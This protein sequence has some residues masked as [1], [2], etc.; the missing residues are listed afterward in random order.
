[1][2][3]GEYFIKV[4]LYGGYGTYKLSIDFEEISEEVDKEPNDDSDNAQ[5]ITFKSR[6][7]MGILGGNAD[8]RDTEDWYKLKITRAGTLTVKAKVLNEGFNVQLAIMDTNG[9]SQLVYG[10]TSGK[11]NGEVQ[12]S[13]HSMVPGEYFIKVFL[14]GGYGTY[15]LSIDFQ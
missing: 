15:K 6:E 13:R 9:K 11:P 7:T 1:M 14:Y 2:V 3:P 5:E 10:R 4:F 8:K 12:L